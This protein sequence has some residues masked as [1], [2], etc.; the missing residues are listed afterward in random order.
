M[1]RISASLF[2]LVVLSPLLLT[3]SRA[4]ALG[5]CDFEVPLAKDNGSVT[6]VPANVPAIPAYFRHY[7]GNFSI[8]WPTSLVARLQDNSTITFPTSQD[9]EDSH[10]F[11]LSPSGVMM[12]G[13][14]ALDWTSECKQGTNA[15]ISGAG[16]GSIVVTPAAALPSVIGTVQD[17]PIGNYSF[18]S[19]RITLSNEALPYLDVATIYAGTEAQGR[20][21]VLL[22]DGSY[23]NVGYE[24]RYVDLYFGGDQPVESRPDANTLVSSVPRSYFGA[25]ECDGKT[26][27]T[28]IRMNVAM[29]IAGKGTAPPPLSFD[30]AVDCDLAKKE[31]GS[32]VDATPEQATVSGEDAEFGVPPNGSCSMSPRSSRVANAFG[33][34]GIAAAALAVMRRARRE[35][36]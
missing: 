16:T 17:N 27:V 5:E 14:L 10:V 8:P 20:N 9:A 24:T 26:G 7:A 12:E 1:K 25:G 4:F 35:V 15:P 34:L 28:P 19:V 3:S 6:H 32:A 22:L 11:L 23:G 31:K 21:G 29:K 36:A 18:P 2:Q 13:A 30:L 33:L